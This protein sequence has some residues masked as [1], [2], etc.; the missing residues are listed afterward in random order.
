[1]TLGVLA[2][3][4]SPCHC[5][6]LRFGVVWYAPSPNDEIRRLVAQR[7][8]LGVTGLSSGPDRLAIKRLNPEFRWFVYWSATDDYVPPHNQ[9]TPEHDALLELARSRKI[10]PEVGYLHYWDDTVIKIQGVTVTIP[11]W[12]TGRAVDPAAARVPVYYSTLVRRAKSFAT[13][14]AR[15]LHREVVVALRIDVPFDGTDLYAGGIFLDNA[16]GRLFNRGEVLSGGHVRELPNHDHIDSREFRDWYFDNF[17][18]FLADLK[19]T[20]ETSARWSRDGQRKELMVNVSNVWDEEYVRRDVADVLM[21]EYQYN[22]VRNCGVDAIEKA[23]RR[24]SLAAS[25]GIASFYSASMT[26]TVN[27]RK[28]GL[29]LG[30]IML[31]NFAWYLLCRSPSSLFYQQGTTAPSTAGW[32][33]LTWRGVMDVA[34]A[35]LG[36]ALAPPYTI[37]TGTDP[38]KNP[39]AV[40]ARRYEKGLVLLRNRGSWKEGVEPETAVWVDL[41]GYL[42]PV[43]PSGTVSPVVNRIT[44]RNGEGAILLG[45]PGPPPQQE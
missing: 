44:L 30:E 19:D 7:C 33:T 4:S 2:L 1:M 32:D 25:A 31:G 3:V 10:D 36:S 17:T 41:P 35:Q 26:R 18:R 5:A 34:A 29:G 40:Q 37:A 13:P 23:H 12:G 43:K 20:L 28:G 15:R 38:L 45:D 8:D 11:G 39:Y 9:G 22:P 6:E 14:T 16:S 21:M 24:D 42:A 27:G